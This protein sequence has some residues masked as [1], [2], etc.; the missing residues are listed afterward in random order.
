MAQPIVAIPELRKTD[1][2]RWRWIRWNT[3][4][5]STKVPIIHDTKVKE[6]PKK[7]APTEWFSKSRIANFVRDEPEARFVKHQ[8]KQS[9]TDM[10][11][12]ELV[13]AFQNKVLKFGRRYIRDVKAPNGDL[14]FRA[15]E[16]MR[17]N[18]G[19]IIETSQPLPNVLS[20]PMLASQALADMIQNNRQQ[21]RRAFDRFRQPFISSARP[22]YEH[23]GPYV[24]MSSKASSRVLHRRRLRKDPFANQFASQF[25]SSE[26]GAM[27][28]GF[29]E[30]SSQGSFQ[31]MFID[32]GSSFQSEEDR[33]IA[34]LLVTAMMHGEDEKQYEPSESDRQNMAAVYSNVS[35]ESSYAILAKDINGFDASD[36]FIKNYFPGVLSGSEQDRRRYRK[37]RSDYLLPVQS[38]LDPNQQVNLDVIANNF[39]SMQRR[40]PGPGPPPAPAG[41]VFVP[42]IEEEEDMPELP[43]EDE[44]SF[45][46]ALPP[47]SHEHKEEIHEEKTYVGKSDAEKSIGR[48]ADQFE[49]ELQAQVEKEAQ[50]FLPEEENVIYES[51]NEEEED[52]K[53]ELL[54]E[55]S[56]HTK[57]S[58]KRRQEDQHRMGALGPAPPKPHLHAPIHGQTTLHQERKHKL[59]ME[60]LE[61]SGNVAPA[62]R[63]PKRAQISMGVNTTFVEPV[64]RT[65]TTGTQT[66]EEKEE[67]PRFQSEKGPI[68]GS[69][70]VPETFVSEKG[71]FLQQPAETHTA[72][73]NLQQEHKVAQN[74]I[75]NH[76]ATHQ[77]T[78]REHMKALEKKE[79]GFAKQLQEKQKQVER[80]QQL[81]GD[82][83]REQKEQ[84]DVLQEVQSSL[85][86]AG[87][88][89]RAFQDQET[90]HKN[91]LARALNQNDTKKQQELA[92]ILDN[93]EVEQNKL[94]E[95]ISNLME[96]RQKG[97]SIISDLRSKVN[98][99]QK[100]FNDHENQLAR[101][102]N[103][104]DDLHN[105]IQSMGSD[106]RKTQNDFASKVQDNQAMQQIV[107]QKDSTINQLRNQIRTL[108]QNELNLKQQHQREKDDEIS[109]LKRGAK[110][111]LLDIQLGAQA[112]AEHNKLLKQRLQQ[113]ELDHKQK[114]SQFD[115]ERD[116]LNAQIARLKREKSHLEQKQRQNAQTATQP[117]VV[118]SHMDEDEPSS[119]LATGHRIQ[120]TTTFLQHKKPKQSHFSH[121]MDQD[122]PEGD[123]KQDLSSGQSYVPLNV[124]TLT[125]KKR[126]MREGPKIPTEQTRVHIDRQ[127]PDEQV[128]AQAA[129]TQQNQ[130]ISQP[131]PAKK[132]RGLTQVD[133][134]AVNKIVQEIKK[135]DEATPPPEDTGFAFGPIRREQ[136]PSPAPPLPLRPKTKKL[137][138]KEP[139][140]PSQTSEQKKF[141]KFTNSLMKFRLDPKFSAR[142]NQML[143][144]SILKVNPKYEKYMLPMLERIQQLG[145]R[146]ALGVSE[147]VRRKNIMEEILQEFA[148]KPPPSRMPSQSRPRSGVPSAEQGDLGPESFTQRVESAQSRSIKEQIQR[149]DELREKERRGRSGTT[150][151]LSR[152]RKK[153]KKKGKSQTRTKTRSKT[154]T[155][156]KKKRSKSRNP[157]ID[158]PIQQKARRAQRKRKKKIDIG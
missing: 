139:Q 53:T 126:Q 100:N 93:N 10:S 99:Y 82:S 58:I 49:D 155:K 117:S 32:E 91:E 27:P 121:R 105:K 55:H 85:N 87:R 104:L 125:G 149:E 114:V 89:L 36:Y 3:S 41:R 2:N 59:P 40:G 29:E 157:L 141:I 17:D 5:D 95:K 156:T 124:N 9:W 57:A 97:L 86:E 127:S 70:R 39:V 143:K 128:T 79:I 148:G 129:Q 75:K 68:L 96:E 45:H 123:V 158:D 62:P 46:E 28:S 47:V 1:C 81:H 65:T 115:D 150:Q 154:R 138:S 60:V 56:K 50:V 20:N 71:S 72:Y 101:S 137:E 67:L 52:E 26:S 69:S 63:V 8:D 25:S 12:D 38:E 66:L 116:T 64:R 23:I 130:D 94:N 84:T 30:K 108:N 24:D 76:E 13:N 119:N 111:K 107:Q 35:S 7:L 153:K 98:Q 152:G 22:N 151:P 102:K 80:A 48:R 33:Q 92:K 103:E 135:Q 18:Q 11:F 112:G 136:E 42:P 15:G 90:R 61:S 140:A 147:G 16:Y 4:W 73:N 54:S 132:S 77:K 74:I 133:L 21:G 146:P 88:R 14:L 120:N 106:L 6:L 43:I 134:A 44:P 31:T 34:P 144:Q 113:M 118:V 83:L 51:P 142:S 109:H 78:L 122:D 145:S 131:P 37:F 110:S 19:N